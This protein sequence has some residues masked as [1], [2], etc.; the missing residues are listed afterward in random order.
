MKIELL[1]FTG[2]PNHEP[3]A[4]RVRRVVERLGVHADID[5]VEVT[6]EDDPAALKFLGSPTVLIDGRDLD[7]AQRD[8]GRY[9]LSCRMFAGQGMPSETLI[10]QGIREVQV[11]AGRH[12]PDL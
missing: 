5:K 1:Y 7:P 3:T 9:G 4:A 2:C 12:P 6:P 8:G 10:E 11:P